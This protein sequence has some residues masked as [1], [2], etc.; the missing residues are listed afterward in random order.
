MK[1][2]A[3]QAK[4]KLLKYYCKA[5]CLYSITSVLDP[6]INMECFKRK[7]W[8]KKDIDKWKKPMENIWKNE[9]KPKPSS[10]FT[11]SIGKILNRKEDEEFLDSIY[12]KKRRIS[13][14]DELQTYVIVCNALSRY[15]YAH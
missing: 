13:P 15:L 12:Q 5:T 3:E 7:K 2:A 1:N 4:L 6:H 14:S 11:P 9:Y 8:E 10:L